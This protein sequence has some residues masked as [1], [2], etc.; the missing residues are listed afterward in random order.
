M[1]HSLLV[2]GASG[3]LGQRVLAHLLDTLAVPS[4]RIV[5]ASRQPQKLADW[6]AR[7]VTTRTADFEQPDT[8]RAA[9]AGIE[10]ALFISTDALDVPGRRLQQHRNA[11]QALA[12]AGV[13]HVIYTSVPNPEN[14]PLLIAPDHEQTEKALAASAIPGWTVLRNHSYFDNL[15][16]ALPAAL[17]SGQWY[18]ADE[19]QKAADISRDDLALAA[20]VALAGDAS[21]KQTLTLSGS[22]ALSKAEKAATISAATGR[23]LQVVQ[24]PLEGLVE[25][26]IGAGLPE[27]LARVLASFD[28]NIAQH[29]VDEVSDDFQRLTG[30]APQS[31]ADWVQQHQVALK[32]L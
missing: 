5:A 32:A 19:G 4:D 7:G 12:Q 30:R 27:G 21:G 25:G 17:A 1:P 3:Q 22:Q 8:L 10:R 31:F 6:A 9:S 2:T 29:F 20:A 18:T 15:Y 16:M 28:T 24:V 23:P 26:M 11:V 14:A 13:Q